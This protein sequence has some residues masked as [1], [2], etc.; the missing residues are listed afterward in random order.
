MPFWG[1]EAKSKNYQI[2]P[3]VSINLGKFLFSQV[4]QIIQI[5]LL[6][7]KLAFLTTCNAETP[8]SQVPRQFVG[9][10]SVK[11]KLTFKNMACHAW[12]SEH[13]SQVRYTRWGFGYVTDVSYY[14]SVK[15]K[16][17]ANNYRVLQNKEIQYEFF[18]WGQKSQWKS[19][20]Q[21]SF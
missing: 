15:K 20:N 2:S 17:Y 14:I 5:F 21:A 12:L 19:E 10:C 7:Q 13:H 16:I 3:A 1:E 8:L 18:N 9:K 11:I 4:F 6:C